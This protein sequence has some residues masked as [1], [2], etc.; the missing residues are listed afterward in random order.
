MRFDPGS[1]GNHLASSNGRFVGNTDISTGFHETSV[2]PVT[3]DLRGIASEK[4][5]LILFIG[6]KSVL[7]E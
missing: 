1:I 5:V 6:T 4:H 2:L 7:D 3:R